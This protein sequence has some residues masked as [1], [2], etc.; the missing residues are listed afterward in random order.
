[1]EGATVETGAVDS[2]L[3]RW[4]RSPGVRLMRYVEIF[5]PV[6]ADSESVAVASI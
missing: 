6:V 3:G 5:N 4:S 1:M 2:I